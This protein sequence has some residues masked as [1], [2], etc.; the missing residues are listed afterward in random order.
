MRRIL[1]GLLL[2]L[3]AGS[4]IAAGATGAFFS[5]SETSTGNTFAA[6]AIDLKI[7][8]DSY[9]N[10]NRCTNIGTTDQ[11]NFE[12]QGDASFPVPGTPCTTSWLLDDLKNGHLFFDFTDLKPGDQSEDTISLHVQN[13]AWACMKVVLTSNDDRSS[14]EPELSDGDT[15]EDPNNT[16]DG[17]LAQNLQ[18]FWWA[19]DGDNV[20]ETGEPA[21]SPGVTTLYDLATSTP[22]TAVLADSSG[23]AWGGQGPLPA[24][25]TKYIAKAWCFGTLT[26][27]PVAAGQGVN[28]SVNPGVTCDGKLLNNLTQTDGATV[29]VEFQAVQSRHNPDFRCTDRGHDFAKIVV[30]KKV[31]NDDG[32]NNDVPDFHL[33]I[34][35][36]IVTTPVTSGATTTVS[37]GTYSVSE[38]GVSGYQASFS[39]DCDSEGNITLNPGDLKTCVITNNDKPALITLVKNVTGAPPLADPSTFKM[40]VDGTLVPNTSSIPVTSN[41]NH[42]ITEDP[43]AGYHF[44]N[45]TGAGCPAATTTPIVLSEGQSVT[46]TINNAKD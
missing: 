21:I 28:P 45:I 29:D 24:N 17:E 22:F 46:C 36:G 13:D 27:D 37:S 35:N 10:G 34:D 11:P 2:I 23:N 1:F 18:M 32:G 12:W 6:G 44:V 30:I 19:D 7:D 31:V 3:G 40:R 16:W 8:N 26:L 14:T 15:Q 20:Y 9:Y 41:A 43:K 39:G 4:A 5:D 38:T 42:F 33:F 25:Q